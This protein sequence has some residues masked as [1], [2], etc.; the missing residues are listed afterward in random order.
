MTEFSITPE[1]LLEHRPF[2]QAVAR[3]LLDEAS[4]EDAVQEAM[5]AALRGRPRSESK[6][7]PWLG[8]I[9]RNI[10]LNQRRGEARRAAREEARAR[11]E[12][13]PSADEIYGRFVVQREL[14]EALLVL[15]PEQ[16]EVLYLHYYE[17]LP[18]REVARRVGL[19]VETVRSRIR[20]ALD[21]MRKELDRRVDG[22]REAWCSA[23]AAFALPREA[24]ATSAAVFPAVALTAVAALAIC[25]WW[26]LRPADLDLAP[27]IRVPTRST[28]VVGSPSEDAGRVALPPGDAELESVRTEA[29]EP[30]RGQVLDARTGEPVPRLDVHVERPDGGVERTVTDLDG[31]FVTAP[32]ARTGSVV[33][34]TDGPLAIPV[35]FHG[36]ELS[37]S[38]VLRADVGPTYFLA[39][40]LPAGSSW[41]EL[42]CRVLEPHDRRGLAVV[43]TTPIRDAAA[44]P[45]I[46]LAPMPRNSLVGGGT[47]SWFQLEVASDDL[48]IRG[49]ATVHAHAGVHPEPVRLDLH[50][51]A[52]VLGTLEDEEGHAIPNGR[53]CALSPAGETQVATSDARGR[54]RLGPLSPGEWRLEA[55]EDSCTTAHETLTIQ[56]PRAVVLDFA[57][58]HCETTTLRGRVTTASG[59]LAFAEPVRVRALGEDRSFEARIDARGAFE[60]ELPHCAADGQV[61]EYELLAPVPSRGVWREPSLTLTAPFEEVR[62]HL[63]DRLPGFELG[64]RVFAATTREPLADFQALALPDPRELGSRRALELRPDPV[65]RSAAFDEPAF[66]DLPGVGVTYWMIEAEGYRSARGDTR[67]DTT[68]GRVILDVFLERSFEVT[69]VATTLDGSGSEVPLEGVA[70]RTAGGTLLGETLADGRLFLSLA[71]DPGRLEVHREG[72]RVVSWDGFRAGRRIDGD[73]ESRIRMAPE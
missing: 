21:S 45:W 63:D 18:P 22:G 29:L 24:A 64:F 68:A 57:L 4:A 14:V 19:P 36:E 3:S 55:A 71:Y 20:R 53:V 1:M 40:P 23:L 26:A 31:R 60:L 11:A 69:F 15:Q 28:L 39:G 2:M 34:L 46:R 42:T 37:D 16:R 8:R 41:S 51:G 38:L 44:T 56:E 13:V 12:A 48:S 58:R 49:A 30:L 70:V 54:Y 65:P 73:P 25:A 59:A 5:L 6:L 62:L 43:A 27:A 9:V 32:V 66:R 33:S 17:G 10:A 52:V 47:R 61:L 72:W 50:R 67:A 7:R 35:P